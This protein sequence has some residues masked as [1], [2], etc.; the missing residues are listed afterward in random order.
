MKMVKYTLPSMLLLA[1]PARAEVSPPPPLGYT[2]L[3]FLPTNVSGDGTTVIG[4]LAPDSDLTLNFPIWTMETGTTDLF[5]MPPSNSGNYTSS[6][7][8][9]DGRFVGGTYAI[10]PDT[11]PNDFSTF[12]SFVPTYIGFIL[13]REN[14][15]DI[16]TFENYRI[17]DIDDTGSSGIGQNVTL[18]F[19]GASW[20]PGL[21]Q[22]WRL[23]LSNENQGSV[24][25]IAMDGAGIRAVGN[26]QD[27]N[28]FTK[29]VYWDL[30]GDAPVAID[31]PSLPTDTEFHSSAQ[32]ISRNGTFIVGSQYD[33]I[34]G[35]DGL[36]RPYL[37]TV[38]GD[39][40]E[41]PVL[42]GSASGVSNT[43]RVV[44]SVRELFMIVAS[45]DRFEQNMQ[46]TPGV[47]GAWV[48]DEV[49][50]VRS[51]ND[52]LVESGA[53]AGSTIFATADAISE[54]GKVIVGLLGN[55]GSDV[56]SN[57]GSVGYIARE[58]SGAINPDEFSP[59]LN[60][61]SEPGALGYNLLNMT[62]H[63]AHHVPLQMQGAGR[64]A[65]ITGDFARNDRYDSDSALVEV[66][67][68]MDFMDK[69]LVAGFGVGQSWVE[70]DLIF[71]GDVE[72]DGQ[73]LLGELSYRANGSPLIF[74][75][76]GGY[77]QWDA[78]IARNYINGPIIDTSFG[79]SDVT[80]GATRVR[81]DWLDAATVGGFGITPKLE[82]TFTRTESD[83]YTEVGGGFPA[84][85]NSQ[86]ESV[87]Q[88]RYGLTAARKVMEDKGLL[89]L[90][91]EGVHRFDDG[92][93]IS[94]GTVI[95][96]G[97]FN[98]VGRS[99]KQNWLFVG[100]DFEYAVSE[101]MTI[102]SGLSTSTD[103]QD[104]IFGSTLGLRVSF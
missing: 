27:T 68:A 6:G 75:L 63:G 104:P 3:P 30:E 77:G 80:S 38:G 46:I 10:F 31:I 88:L 74:T 18:N 102:T 78:D 54:D 103:G 99:A 82:Y 11:N 48:Y 13:D 14:P 67:A 9:F 16:A 41:I 5:E 71:G 64:Y 8:S 85:F 17:Y 19:G 45:L 29:S 52:W 26:Q 98:V 32:D 83:A 89:R 56:E 65:W 49:E 53:N 58:G 72:M 55:G 37:F 76:T 62:L 44:G 36:D 34:D 20:L 92:N 47:I 95:G 69:Q 66:G 23:L 87:H 39:V 42:D 28:L 40:V 24:Y 81:A 79:N 57:G 35:D 21:D 94:S 84:L 51:I 90:R 12:S 101:Q 43:G 15:D 93:A 91:A 4:Y 33:L 50:G 60:A 97:P 100:F 1:L 73:Y 22:E 96:L 70:Q 2:P 59:T 61:G 7:I 25:A 86:D